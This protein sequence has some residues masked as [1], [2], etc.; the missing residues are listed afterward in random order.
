MNAM[1][2]RFLLRGFHSLP[3][4]YAILLDGASELPVLVQVY[5][6]CEQHRPKSYGPDFWDVWS[7][8]DADV[9]IAECKVGWKTIANDRRWISAQPQEQNS[10][11]SDE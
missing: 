6:L 10:E 3:S 1:L 9:K 5:S 2:S 4:R 8:K 11:S 7:D